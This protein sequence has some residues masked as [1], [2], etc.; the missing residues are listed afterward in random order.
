MYPQKVISRRSIITGLLQIRPLSRVPLAARWAR[1]VRLV[2]CVVALQFACGIPSLFA[3]QPLFT[4][5]KAADPETAIRVKSPDISQVVYR[6]IT[7]ET[8]Q[9]W[10]SFEAK[11]DFELF[12]QI[13]VP[14]IDRLK[15]FRPAMA[16]VGPGL[17]ENDPPFK[18][19]KNCGLKVLTT[20]DVE[21]PEFFHEPFTNTDSWILRSET[22][23]LPADGVYYLVGYSPENRMGKLWLSLGKK[24]S[25]GLADILK[26]PSWLKKVQAFHEVKK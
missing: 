26:F 3:H 17:P 12:V 25:F 23:K 22:M 11:K 1:G 14:A 5:D 4:D 20:K 21:K 9:I 7:K 24:E 19:P 18:L 8:P 2:L 6:E 10:L 15:D 13:G 16:I